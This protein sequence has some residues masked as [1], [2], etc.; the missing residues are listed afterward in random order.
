MEEPKNKEPANEHQQK[1]ELEEERV[2][3][4]LRACVF[5]IGGMKF[6]IPLEFLVEIVEIQEVFFLPLAPEY[7]AGMI[8]YR[9]RAVPLIDIGT[10]Y[11]NPK[12]TPA[13]GSPAI[14]TEYAG[15]LIAFLS[16]EIPNLSEEFEGEPI[17]MSEFFDTYRVR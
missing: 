9:G 1:P 17:E 5:S 12:K 4:E 3:P 11:N 8:H 16:D 14:V 10:L 6:S 13:E 15:E 7:I 2:V